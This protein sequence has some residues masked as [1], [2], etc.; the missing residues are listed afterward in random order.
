MAL[1]TPASTTP[2]TGFDIEWETEQ[3]RPPPKL[4]DECVTETTLDVV[5]DDTDETYGFD[6]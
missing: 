3:A 1:S 6:R 2:T 4:G 5:V